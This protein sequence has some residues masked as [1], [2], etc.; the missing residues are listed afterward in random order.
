MPVVLKK[1][2]VHD[3]KEKIEQGA[4]LHN[5]ELEEGHYKATT[6]AGNDT[7]KLLKCSCG[8][9]QAYDLERTKA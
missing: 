2:H 9:T 7:I 1:D 4:L 5:Y 6:T 3:F 8:Q